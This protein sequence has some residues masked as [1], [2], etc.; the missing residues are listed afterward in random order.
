MSC[1]QRPPL[2]QGRRRHVEVSR[3]AVLPVSHLKGPED[4]PLPCPPHELIVFF[5]FSCCRAVTTGTRTSVRGG[6]E[7]RRLDFVPKLNVLLASHLNVLES[8]FHFRGVFPFCAHRLARYDE[9][10]GR[11]DALGEVQRTCSPQRP[12]PSPSV[13]VRGRC[14]PKNRRGEKGYKIVRRISMRSS[15]TKRLTD[16]RRKRSCSTGEGGGYTDPRSRKH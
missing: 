9:V 10:E 16:D 15:T 14:P 8:H 6:E 7:G 3:T 12:S 13:A 5:F 2:L 4:L 1:V 11:D